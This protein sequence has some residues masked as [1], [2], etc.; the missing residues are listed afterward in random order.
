MG[1]EGPVIGLSV[2]LGS[3]VLVYGTMC[4][5]RNREALLKL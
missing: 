4:Y 3:L 2:V 5:V 1:L